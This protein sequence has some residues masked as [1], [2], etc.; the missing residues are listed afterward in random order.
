MK[1]DEF[2]LTLSAFL[3]YFMSFLYEKATIKWHGK[4]LKR[5]LFWILCTIVGGGIAYKSG[6]LVLDK[7]EWSS[8]E[9]IFLS[10][11]AILKWAVA[12]IF[13]GQQF[14]QKWIHKTN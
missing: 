4:D 1:L 3:G 12:I 9:G 5:W 6:E 10:I 11:A 7:L 13:C 14:F 8:E 2:W